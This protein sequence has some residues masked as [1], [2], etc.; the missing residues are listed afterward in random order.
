[1]MNLSKI[2]NITILVLSLTWSI[3]GVSQETE[4]NSNETFQEITPKKGLRLGLYVG[5]YF[6]NQYTSSIYDGYGFDIDGNKNNW[7]NSLMNQKINMEYGGYGFQGAPDLIAQELNLDYHT[8]TF[9]ASDMPLNMR[10][11]PSFSVGLNCIYSVDV[12]NAILLNV[13]LAKLNIG[14]N[15]TIITPQQSGSSQI[16]D[17]IK[18]FAIKGVEQRMMFQFGY[19]RILGDNEKVNFFVEGGLHVTVTKFDKNEILINT[20]K[21]DLTTYYNS[22]A[23]SSALLVKKPI[24]TGLGVFAGFGT[25]LTINPKFTLQLLYSPT[26]ERV[27]IGINPRLKLQN[28]IGLRAY[29][30]L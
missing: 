12:K 9:N 25:N 2:F 14:G 22:V 23:Y 26:Y 7:E 20:L 21:I 10:Y 15:F 3:N 19:Q 1:M 17:R 8:W 5:S 24:G 13:N 18:T 30:N 11:T 6:A 29:Y 28:A 4:D 27:N 16:N